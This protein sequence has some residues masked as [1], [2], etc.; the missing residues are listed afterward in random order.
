MRNGRARTICESF[1]ELMHA[2][3]RTEWLRA[4]RLA[5][6]SDG[7]GRWSEQLVELSKSWLAAA[8]SVA[9]CRW[10]RV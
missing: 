3:K 4:N 6:A 10:W 8:D 5:D 1:I 9:E 2:A 7:V